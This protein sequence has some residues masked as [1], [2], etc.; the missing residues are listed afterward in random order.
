[1]TTMGILFPILVLWLGIIM[2]VGKG[3]NQTYLL[4]WLENVLLGTDDLGC[5]PSSSGFAFDFLC[6]LLNLFSQS[7]QSYV[8]D[9]R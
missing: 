9:Q 5:V 7:L 8:G 1:M 4:C 3:S 6:I 2:K